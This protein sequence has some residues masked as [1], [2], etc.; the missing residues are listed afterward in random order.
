MVHKIWVASAFGLV[1]AASGCQRTSYQNNAAYVPPP[2]AAQPVGQ[3]QSGS[4]PPPGTTSG[5]YGDG[6]YNN[7]AGG[8]PTVDPN[9]QFPSAPSA[10]TEVA[11]AGDMD[12]ITPPPG[13]LPVSASALVGSWKVDN[14]GGTCDMFLTLTNLGDGQRGGTRGCSGPLTSM[15]SWGINGDQVILKDANGYVIGRLYMTAANAVSGL[16]STG[17]QLTL[18]R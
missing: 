11:A 1:L 16:S 18:S 2:L 15:K 17:Q 13:A 8:S 3:V 6:T 10:P 12:N 4:L 5:T 14:G 7:T 9:T